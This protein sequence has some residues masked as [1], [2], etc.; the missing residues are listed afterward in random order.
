MHGIYIKID[1]N[2]VVLT[3]FIYIHTKAPLIFST[4]SL[5]TSLLVH[6]ETNFVP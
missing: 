3:L 2:S 6:N 5:M 1:V 4:P